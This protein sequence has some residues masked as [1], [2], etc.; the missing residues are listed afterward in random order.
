MSRV[1]IEN[2]T[3]FVR[4]LVV[5]GDLSVGRHTY[6]N[7]QY[8]HGFIDEFGTGSAVHPKVDPT[9]PD[10]VPRIDRRIGDYVVAG[11]DLKLASDTLLLRLFAIVKLPSV[12]LATGAFD[13]Y[14]FTGVLFPQLDWTV[15]EGTDL[16]LGAFVFLG[17]RS[18]KFGDPAAG[19]SEL[20]AKARFC[21]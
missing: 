10:E 20:F 11:G 19:A 16:L 15:W 17:D 7:L 18:T 5:G 13:D 14:K 12:D 4:P 8:L 1:G 21:Y 9:N 6:F 3:E 2:Q